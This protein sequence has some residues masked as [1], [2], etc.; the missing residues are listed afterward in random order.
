VVGLERKFLL[1][2]RLFLS[3][4]VHNSIYRVP[5]GTVTESGE[6]APADSLVTNFYQRA[7][8]D[9]RDSDTQPR[10]GVML[11]AEVQEAGISDISSWRYV[12]TTPDARV[13]LP[14]PLDAVLAARFAVGMYFIFFADPALDENS[15]KL[16]PRDYRLRGGGATSNRGFLP[17]ELGDGSDGGTRRWE[18]SLELRLP[19]T[20]TVGLV[21]FID[22]GDV[23]QKPQFRWDHPQASSGFGLRYRTIVGSLRLDFAWRLPGLQ[24]FGTDE[25]YPGGDLNQV[26]F[27]FAKMNGAVH[28]TIGE[29]F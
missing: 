1:R 13:Y 3:V 21:G 11:Q 29:A 20:P 23:S 25:R 14:L 9:F 10:R 8:L 12:R 22:A 28:L 26:D 2:E 7:R 5:G 19:V 18:A 24:V 15:R 4:G 6:P 17:G 16:G 27:G